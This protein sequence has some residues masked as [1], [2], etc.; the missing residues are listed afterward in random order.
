MRK[1]PPALALLSFSPSCWR[2]SCPVG[3]NARP[4]K[5][6]A[7][8]LWE[9]VVLLKIWPSCCLGSRPVRSRPL[10]S[11]FSGG[12]GEKTGLE[13]SQFKNWYTL[14]C[15]FSRMENSD[16]TG[17][18]NLLSLVKMHRSY[19][20]P[21]KYF[22]FIPT[23]KSMGYNMNHPYGINKAGSCMHW[24]IKSSAWIIISGEK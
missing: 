8:L 4:V 21:A 18:K 17:F 16:L 23:D 20:T 11:R 1:C 7:V 24:A 15:D 12:F 14:P 10:L 22:L 6:F 13:R 19:G 5:D 9:I 3:K 2:E